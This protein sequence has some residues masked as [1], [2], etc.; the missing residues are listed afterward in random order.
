MKNEW[1]AVKVELVKVKDVLPYAMNSRVHSDEQVNQIASSIQEWGFTV[2][3]L[4][5][6]KN[7]ILAGHGR[8][9]A[10]GKLSLDEVPAMKATNW[11]EA[12]KKS[13]CNS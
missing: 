9:M 5:D 10:A 8:I 1:P 13:I 12:Q 11:T 2:P 6:E 3:I 7:T 4:I